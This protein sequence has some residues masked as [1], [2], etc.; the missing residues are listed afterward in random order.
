MHNSLPRPSHSQLELLETGRGWV[1][2]CVQRNFPSLRLSAFRSGVSLHRLAKQKGEEN[3]PEARTGTRGKLALQGLSS[4][5]L[6]PLRKIYPNWKSSPG[7]ALKRSVRQSAIWTSRSSSFALIA[8]SHSL[9]RLVLLHSKNY[10]K[11]WFRVT[12]YAT[13]YFLLNCTNLIFKKNPILT[14]TNS[15]QHFLQI[16]S[17]T[18][19]YLCFKR[20]IITNQNT[21]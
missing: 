7:K 2:K 17:D 12:P 1:G 9:T 16:S 15:K 8:H 5:T 19:N 18:N 20:I 4:R 14:S 10:Y 21:I 13:I 3:G 6:P 11:N